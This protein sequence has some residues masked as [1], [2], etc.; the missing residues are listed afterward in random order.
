M[1]CETNTVI[2]NWFGLEMHWAQWWLF[3]LLSRKEPYIS[4][5]KVYATT[6]RL[7][8][9]F[10]QISLGELCCWLKQMLPPRWMELPEAPKLNTECIAFSHRPLKP[11]HV[12]FIDNTAQS[13]GN[14]YVYDFNIYETTADNMWI[15]WTDINI[16]HELIYNCITYWGTH[17]VTAF[18]II[19]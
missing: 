18:V 13:Y 12:T 4:R 6:R 14:S 7:P 2:M 5:L 11:K 1:S 19:A 3:K 8:T 17:N 10:S 9:M 16:S 15:T